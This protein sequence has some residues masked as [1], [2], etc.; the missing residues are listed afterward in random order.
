MSDASELDGELVTRLGWMQ[1][2]TAFFVAQVG[3]LSDTDLLEAS[4]LP[5][6][7]RRHVLSHMANNAV[8]LMNLLDWARTGIETPMYPSREARA[9][10]IESGSLRPAA[11]L[12]ADALDSAER[13][14]AATN[15]MPSTAWDAPVRT[16]LGLVVSGAEVPWMRTRE[17]WVHGVDIGGTATF[18]DVDT[19]VAAALLDEAAR[20]FAGRGDCPAVRLV[21]SDGDSFTI[22]PMGTRATEVLGTVHSLGAWLLGRSDGADLETLGLLPVLP[23]WL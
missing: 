22:G 21:A 23:T 4:R 18:A 3:G 6:W 16:A 11:D 8:A 9:A 12:R 15:A 10:D 13:L 5:G 1:A 19:A 20:S 17:V 2:G 14:A 7:T